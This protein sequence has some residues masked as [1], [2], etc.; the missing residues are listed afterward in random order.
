[1]GQYASIFLTP[2]AKAVSKLTHPSKA[3]W[4]TSHAIASELS[5]AEVE[6]LWVRF[7]QLGANKDGVLTED[8]IKKSDYVGDV[9]MRNILKKYM[10]ATDRKISFEN[11][12]RA[13]KWVEQAE[14]EEKV[15]GIYH[16][17]NNG[18]PVDKNLMGK[19]LERVYPSDKGEPIKRI[20]EIFFQMMDR[21]NKGSVDEEGFVQ[22]VQLIHKDTLEHI[23]TFAILPE[24]MKARLHKNLP[25][26]RSDS[27]AI[28]G[29]SYAPRQTPK[30]GTVPPDHALRE[31]AE[32]IHKKDWARVANKLDFFSQDVDEIR[33]AYPDSTS[34]QVYQMLKQWRER[35]GQ[36]AYSHVLERA[37]VQC[38]MND[39]AIIMTS[40]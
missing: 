38:D 39:A 11:F 22:G 12:L 5:I 3:N 30:K 18:N 34:Q 35:D 23:L 6:R 26:F 21:N 19:I 10:A 2:E 32:K 27:A 25:E 29:Q 13:L 31:V 8:A 37:L 9:F 33:R 24:E 40:Y 28:G 7:Q 15:R 17:L 16:M 20:V 1:M 14:T 36:E 4:I